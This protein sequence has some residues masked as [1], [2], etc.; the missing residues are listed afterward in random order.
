MPPFGTRKT[1]T[2]LS[3]PAPEP[4]EPSAAER[5]SA[6]LTEQAQIIASLAAHQKERARLLREDG[7]LD[8]LT[9][10]VTDDDRLR[11]RLEQIATQLPDVQ[12]AVEQER[13][14]AW[15]AEWLTHRPA[16]AA[17]EVELEAAIRGAYATYVLTN[18]MPLHIGE[19]LATS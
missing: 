12:A 13:R 9:A 2:L 4:V 18:S 19:V 5:L 10:L 3:D 6:L 8:A 16:L 7:Q 17:I 14:A 15:E 1:A 11:L